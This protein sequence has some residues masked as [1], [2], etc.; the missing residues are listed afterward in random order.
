MGS[1]R[2]SKD[3]RWNYRRRGISYKNRIKTEEREVILYDKC[4][5]KILRWVFNRP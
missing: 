2:N 4:T 5:E 1:K 3:N